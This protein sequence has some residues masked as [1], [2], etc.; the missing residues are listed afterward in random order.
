MNSALKIVTREKKSKLAI[1]QY[2]S[3][4][5]HGTSDGN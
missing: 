1:E 4:F 2:G 3:G 5:D